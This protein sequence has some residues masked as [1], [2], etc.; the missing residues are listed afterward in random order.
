MERRDRLC[1]GDMDEFDLIV[2]VRIIEV[3]VYLIFVFHF[4][5]NVAASFLIEKIKPFI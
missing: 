2:E 1:F 5:A 3:T 4:L